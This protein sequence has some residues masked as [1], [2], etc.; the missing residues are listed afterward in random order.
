MQSTGDLDQDWDNLVASFENDFID[1]LEVEGQ[2]GV[3]DS[4]GSQQGKL[5]LNTN[6][7]NQEILAASPKESRS[8]TRDA[9]R[10]RRTPL[11]VPYNKI[12]TKSSNKW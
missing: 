1:T 8:P 11:D 10:S 5:G 12:I 6:I 7:T 2:E 9:V 3:W 4:S